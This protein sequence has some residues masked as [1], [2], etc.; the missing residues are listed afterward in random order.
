[1]DLENA[2]VARMLR[3]YADLLEAQGTDAYRVRAYRAA[4]HTVE[5]V[6]ESLPE[7]V[8]RDPAGLTRLPGIGKSIAARIAEYIE[9]GSVARLE[10]LRRSAPPPLPALRVPGLGPQRARALV[11][12]LG[13]SS[14]EELRSAAR[15]GRV[16]AVPGFG[17]KTEERLLRELDELGNAAPVVPR[18]VAL[19]AAEPLLAVARALPGVVAA[20]I[21]GDLRRRRD[22]AERVD[23][24]LAARDPA[25]TLDTMARHPE[26]AELGQ[27][28]GERFDARLRG[29]LPLRVV[30]SRPGQFGVALHAATGSEAHVQALRALAATRGVDLARVRAAD[31]EELF[32]RLALPWIPPELREGRGEIAAARAG[33][34]PRL[35]TR[36]DLRGDLQMHTTATDGRDTLEAMARAAQARGYEYIAITEHT[37]AVRVVR[38]LDAEGFRRQW[39]EIDALNRRLAGVRVLKSVEVDILG[40][41][42]L[43]LDDQTLRGFDLVLASIHS[44]FDLPEKEQTRRVLRALRHPS[45]DVFAHPE[46][47]RIGHRRGARFD[48]EA[49]IA[50]AAG[51]GKAIEINASPDRLDATAEVARDAIGKGV[52]LT[53]STDAHSTSELDLVGWG[54]DQAR[55][56]WAEPRHVLNALALADLLARLPRRH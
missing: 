23:L 26:I 32:S 54:V 25:R 6:V 33:T 18:Y 37:P 10:E 11:Q 51:L 12:A 45:V 40:D 1:M 53:I 22:V 28:D 48:W 14:L 17:A 36:E 21:A 35:I 2:R 29:G 52:L 44:K 31:E 55:R 3:D 47:R 27:R 16:R 7:L 9:T 24:A 50:A 13:V 41:G 19:E 5:R 56:A 43:D 30:A 42:A 4:A 34:L 46:G 39:R 38:G 15:A 20:E 49:V 8:R